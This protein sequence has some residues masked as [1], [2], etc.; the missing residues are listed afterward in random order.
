MIR[1]SNTKA[2]IRL[3]KEK[4]AKTRMSVEK[5]ISEMALKNERI[6][7]NSVAQKSNVS[8]SW[9][10]KQLDIR[11]RIE[12]LRGQQIS[13][14]KPKK[15]TKSVRSETMLIQTLKSRIK[16]LEL[17]N[18]QLKEQVQKLYGKLF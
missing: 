11:T 1:K 4:S 9:L 15:Y 17:E 5:A 18:R 6:N 12:T 10:Y 7:F 8:K 2:I 14:C 3:S 16:V 13:A